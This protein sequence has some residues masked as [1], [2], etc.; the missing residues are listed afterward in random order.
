MCGHMNVKLNWKSYWNVP[1]KWHCEMLGPKLILT[2]SPLVPGDPGRLCHRI[3]VVRKPRAEIILQ[4]D[5]AMI[6][7]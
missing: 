1:S 6:T 2:T 4:R 5:V 3:S 7:H